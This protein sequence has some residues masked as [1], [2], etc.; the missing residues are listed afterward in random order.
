MPSSNQNNNRII[1]DALNSIGY[2]I[3]YKTALEGLQE[4]PRYHLGSADSNT[5]PIWELK[6]EYFTREVLHK[7]QGI[8]EK[9]LTYDPFDIEANFNPKN[10]YLL[11]IYTFPNVQM[12]WDEYIF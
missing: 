7:L 4:S 9:A 2:C 6:E 10:I 11:Y 8:Y 12:K 3:K 1:I 5:T